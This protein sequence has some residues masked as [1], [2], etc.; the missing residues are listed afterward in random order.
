MSGGTLKK[1]V[2]IKGKIL[3]DGSPEKNVYAYWHRPDSSKPNGQSVTNDKGEYCFTSY[4]TCDGLEPGQY[5]LTF[6]WIKKAELQRKGTDLLKGR[7]S[8]LAK[9]EY[10][11]T[12]VE[13]QPQTSLN[14][15]LTTK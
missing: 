7:Y 8:N 9:T 3:I 2:P 14:F 1:V 4:T 5:K 6:Q 10:S 12:V 11:V 13:G 15:E